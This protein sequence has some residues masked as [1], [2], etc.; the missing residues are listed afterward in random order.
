MRPERIVLAQGA[1]LG[2]ESLPWLVLGE[3]AL[4]L[5]H[6]AEARPVGGIDSLTSLVTEWATHEADLRSLTTSPR[7]E[8]I[9]RVR[10]VAVSSLDLEMPIR[11]RQ[12]FC[13]I[14]NYQRQVVQAAADADDGPN[15]AGASKRRS[16][17]V[18]ALRH[19]REIGEPYICLTSSA[20]VAAPVGAL[21]VEDHTLDWEVEIAV[22]LNA[23]IRHVEPGQAGALIAGYC[24]ANDVTVRGKVVRPDLAALGSDWVQSKGSPGSLPLGP[25]FVPAWQVRDVG[26]LRLRLWINGE[27]MQDD[28][29]SDML[30]SVE[31]QVSYLS[32]YT[33]LQA[34][35]LI[36]TGSP[37]GFGSHYG[38]YL[39]PGDVM[40][41]EVSEL[42]G[43]R[44][45]CVGPGSTGREPASSLRGGTEQML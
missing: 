2:G 5:H 17:A 24:T 32:R 21:R 31:E 27:L 6:W 19:R 10:G 39:T 14:G 29:A 23:G 12:V 30:F 45:T 37:A 34:G 35:D 9:L 26:S 13:T 8:D 20:R 22:V 25:W 3:R 33:Q 43:Q 41:A 4:P 42:G 44:V 18:E 7:T 16:E 11:P 15:G 38:R 36:C 40:T 1:R 28:L